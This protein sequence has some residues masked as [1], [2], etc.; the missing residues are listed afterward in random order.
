MTG[1]PYERLTEALRTDA[2]VPYSLYAGGAFGDFVE[3][4]RRSSLTSSQP[5]QAHQRIYKTGIPAWFTQPELAAVRQALEAGGAALDLGCGSASSSLV[6]AQQFPGCRVH[7]VD[8]DAASIEKAA[9]NIAAAEKR[10]EVQPGQVGELLPTPRQVVPHCCFAHEATI[11]PGSLDLVMV[12]IAL[13]D[14]HNPS[15]VRTQCPDPLASRCSP[16]PSPCSSRPALCSFLSS[17]L[18]TPSPLW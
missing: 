17:P 12:F 7:A 2:G 9:R 10:G 13:H 1:P 18:P 5:P 8:C 14:M 6:L 15:E 3:K 11:E 16:P 4:V